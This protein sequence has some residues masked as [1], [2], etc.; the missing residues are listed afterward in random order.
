[1]D[2][3]LGPYSSVFLY[4]SISCVSILVMPRQRARQTFDPLGTYLRLGNSRPWE[5]RAKDGEVLSFVSVPWVCGHKV[6]YVS[7]DSLFTSGCLPRPSPAILILDICCFAN[8]LQLHELHVAARLC[9]RLLDL[10]ITRFD[11][12][13]DSSPALFSSHTHA[14]A[15]AVILQH[16]GDVGDFR[17]LA[18]RQQA[19]GHV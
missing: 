14:N 4:R 1:M 19:P 2:Q 7:Y 15:V 18:G 3:N 5:R 6:R 9:D 8:C 10:P 11:A 12:Q 13:A 16:C 17:V